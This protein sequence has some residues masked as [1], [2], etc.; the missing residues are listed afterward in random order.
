MDLTTMVSNFLTQ[1]SA[2]TW[3]IASPGVLNLTAD[4]VVGRAAAATVQLGTDVNGSPVAQTLKAHNG[5]TGTDVAGA[6][7]T[8]AAGVG[9]GAGQ[10]GILAFQTAPAGTT[11]TTVETLATRQAIDDVGRVVQN[12]VSGAVATC[13]TLTKQLT[14]VTSAATLFTVTVPN[15]AH[16]G[17]VWIDVNGT[18]TDGTAGQAAAY[19]LVLSR[20][21][22]AHILA[23]LSAA[24]GAVATNSGTTT[25]TITN[26]AEG[27]GVTETVSIKVALGASGTATGNATLINHNASGITIA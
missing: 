1:L 7:L 25:V 8:L 15:A 3:T 17:A 9:T 6:N 21:S 22:G 2:G 23:T 26:N 5:I 18:K 16:G 27:V 14:G 12:G 4:T 13:A 24:I 11:G 10:P 20:A 19:L